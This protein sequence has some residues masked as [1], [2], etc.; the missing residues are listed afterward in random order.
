[1]GWAYLTKKVRRPW[2]QGACFDVRHLP[3]FYFLCLVYDLYK[4]VQAGITKRPREV[5]T[6]AR[7]HTQ[8]HFLGPPVQKPSQKYQSPTSIG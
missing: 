6:Y 2:H 5:L 7:S 4:R 3:I 8:K 1:M